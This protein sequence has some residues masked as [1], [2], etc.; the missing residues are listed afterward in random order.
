[1][2]NE[3]LFVIVCR[4]AI[5]WNHQMYMNFQQS[6]SN[7]EQCLNFTDFSVKKGNVLS[8]LSRMILIHLLFFGIHI[9]ELV[10]KLQNGDLEILL[11]N[12]YHVVTL[13][14]Q[15]II[16]QII[17]ITNCFL[18]TR[19]KFLRTQLHSIIQSEKPNAIG[20]KFRK[21]PKLKEAFILFKQISK[22]SLNMSKTFGL[23][24]FLASSSTVI[25]SLNCI[26]FLIFVDDN[27]DLFIYLTH[28][29]IYLISYVIVVLR[30]EDVE[31]ESRKI[32]RFCY[33]NQESLSGNHLEFEL[34]RFADICNHLAPN[35]SAAGFFTFN[36]SVLSAVFSS[37]LAYLITIIQLDIALR[38][39]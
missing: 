9:R 14:H 24:V 5:I 12:L 22:V 34:M 23:H 2:F 36:K 7:M 27:K 29:L 10:I 33:E 3:V 20:L 30:S 21:K 18:F 6:I 1:M 8:M 15:T 28:T 26:V 19:Y 11:Y 31:S 25:I 35:F 32:I 38:K 16:L 13:Y 4:V 39:P 17:T 37:I